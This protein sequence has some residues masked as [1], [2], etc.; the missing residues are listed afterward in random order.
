[1]LTDTTYETLTAYT[2]L[3]GYRPLPASD[4]LP[5]IEAAGIRG[6]GGTGLGQPV[7][8]RW[9]AVLAHSGPRCVLANGAESSPGSRKD[10]Y[11]MERFPHRILDGALA[12][13]R[14]LEAETVYLYIK[15]T[16]TAARE[17]ME[18]ALAELAQPDLPQFEIVLAPESAVAGE[19]T[20]ACDAV[21]GFEGRPQVKPPLPSAVGVL[22]RPTLVV[23]VETL[24][25][26]AAA[27]RGD[28]PHVALFTL[29]GDVHRPGVYALPLGT[30]IRTLIETHGGG[31]TG[32]I[33]A[34]LPGGYRSAPLSPAELDL[35]L[36]YDAL[37]AAGST[38]GPAHVVV[39]AQPHRLGGL[40]AG[41]LDLA[42]L[43]SCNQCAICGEG[44]RAMRTAALH[45]AQGGEP[46]PL[47]AE[48]ERWAALLRGKGNC[49]FPD[50][51]ARM[52]QGALDRFD[53]WGTLPP[54][55]RM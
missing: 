18:A 2:A 30:P 19:E 53:D 54:E 37:Q 23:N 45:L 48:L 16:A 47:R 49:A 10:T 40:M 28:D 32:E 35:P 15:A 38:L 6:R 43:G 4:I 39:L 7:A 24:A 36:D 27:L 20:A 29:S 44:V 46:D 5:L 25:A 22:G 41:A 51:V 31:A 12:A 26:V 9:R 3:G 33:V 55:G 1:M 52:V 50:S 14:V 42:V 21:E 13:A 17:S 34:V 8:Q 11:L